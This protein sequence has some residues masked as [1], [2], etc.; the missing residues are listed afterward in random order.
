MHW[1]A[2][3]FVFFAILWDE[4]WNIY[5]SE[6]H[7]AFPCAKTRVLTYCSSKTVHGITKA[8]SRGTQKICV[9]GYLGFLFFIFMFE[10]TALLGV[11]HRL[12]VTNFVMIWLTVQKLLAFLLSIGNALKVPKNSFVAI[13][14]AKTEI[15]RPIFLNHKG[16]LLLPKHAFWRITRQNRS[17]GLT[18][19]LSPGTQKIMPSAA[20]LDFQ[21]FDFW[22]YC[23]FGGPH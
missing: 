19:A 22:A 8:L 11:R 15:F 21:L 7:K 6:P 4:N 20:I 18:R 5:L 14:G 10:H 13:L 16:Q 17:T 12:C 3:K 23:T 9:G 2:H 1:N